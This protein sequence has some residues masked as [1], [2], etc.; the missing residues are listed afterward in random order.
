MEE[1][2]RAAKAEASQGPLRKT[3]EMTL[4]EAFLIVSASDPVAVLHVDH[5]CGEI[6]A[7]D[8]AHCALDEEEQ[9]TAEDAAKDSR[10]ALTA[11]IAA[12]T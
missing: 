9:Y 7:H 4:R 3:T 1:M 6:I 11:R 12:S 2:A 10:E 5:I 8:S